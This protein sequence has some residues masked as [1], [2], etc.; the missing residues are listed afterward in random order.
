MRLPAPLVPGVLLR[1][2]KRFLA[3]VRLNDGSEVT[4][5][6]PNSGSMQGCSNPGSP[7]HLSRSDAPGRR[8]PFTLELVRTR[9]GAL[10]GVN[11]ARTNRIAEEAILEGRIA[12]L[13]GAAGIRREVPCGRGSR[14]D[15]QVSLR[16]REVFVEVK[17]VTLR[18]G[19]RALF[20]DAVTERG[21]KHLR[22]LV[23][24]R[25]AGHRAA[26]LFIVQR[27]DCR[28]FGPAAEIDPAYAEGLAAARDAGV[29]ILAYGCDVAPDAIVVARRL[30]IAL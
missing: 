2:Y 29:E 19:T 26:M 18:A 13:R 17:N 24:L 28:S 12:P 9:E 6:T 5:H 8:L 27:A 4:A 21:A 20:P 30:R 7:V 15:L 14:L 16:G 23:T 10:V 11:T 22:E 1:R 25:R 3:D